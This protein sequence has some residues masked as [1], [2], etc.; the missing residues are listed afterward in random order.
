MST[1]SFKGFQKTQS[2]KQ[3]WKEMR[4]RRETGE[5]FILEA[6]GRKTDATEK[7]SKTGS[8]VKAGLVAYPSVVGTQD[9]LVGRLVAYWV[10]TFTSLG[11]C[12]HLKYAVKSQRQKLVSYCS[13]V[14]SIPP[15]PLLGMCFIQRVAIGY[16][17]KSVSSGKLK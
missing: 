5:G 15:A 14:G 2:S 16:L 4:A 9:P 6:Q 3:D 13:R 11:F 10:E 7:S 8:L 1:P 12:S 17:E